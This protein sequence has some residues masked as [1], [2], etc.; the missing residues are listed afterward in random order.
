MVS[1]G[2]ENLSRLVMSTEVRRVGARGVCWW[3]KVS[4]LVASAAL[5]VRQLSGHTAVSYRVCR[6]VAV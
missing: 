2:D 6:V 1:A 5:E 4:E 3:S